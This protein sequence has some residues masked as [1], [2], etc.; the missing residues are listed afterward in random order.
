MK[1]GIIGSSYSVGSHV[2]PATN[3]SDLVLPFEHWFDGI[4]VVNAACASKGT[5]LYLNKVVYLKKHHGIDTLLM[6]SVNNRSMLN[7]HTGPQ[8]YD[9][10]KHN[11]NID[12]MVCDVYRDSRSMFA[13]KRYLHQEMD[14]ENYGTLAEYNIWKEFQMNIAAPVPMN[15]FWAITDMAQTIDL[16]KMLGINVI[17]WANRWHMEEQPSFINAMQDQ[18]YVKF[19]NEFNAYDYYSKKYDPDSIRCDSSHFT[20]AVNQEMVADFIMPALL[21]G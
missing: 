8:S 14:Y 12:E 15:E 18:T 1:L 4:D 20:D 6:E 16:C 11:E 7:T 21:N 10:I 9:V 3:K 19:G 13:Y 2:N 5:E 17:T